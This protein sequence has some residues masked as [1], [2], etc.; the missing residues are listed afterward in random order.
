M[1][2]RHPALLILS[3]LSISLY[4]I[5]LIKE[6]FF[7]NLFIFIIPLTIFTT[8]INGLTAHYGVT[9]L[10]TLPS[11]NKVCLEPIVFGLIFG[12]SVSII[13]L[14]FSCYNNTVDSGKLLYLIGGK[15]PKLALIITTA[16]RFFP[17][18]KEKLKE[19]SDCQKCF[20]TSVF[21]G[22]IIERI[23]NGLRILKCLFGFSLEN[24]ID[25]AD[26]MRSRGY[27]LKPRTNYHDFVFTKDDIFVTVFI[28]IS[29]FISILGS[30]FG[31]TKA[32]YNPFIKIPKVDFF[33]VII[34]LFYALLWLAPLIYDI[35][36]LIK[37]KTANKRAKP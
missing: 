31:K 36:Y 7:K 3:F 33:S 23:K 12:A 16:L 34:F 2:F 5:K 28:I 37:W 13:I 9:E 18:Y 29:S 8:L 15:F 24:S 32:S 27:G 6:K 10:F 11:G 35:S 26:S 17:L 1:I 20:G 21:D 19:I 22:S 25:T 14:L 30:V 4:D